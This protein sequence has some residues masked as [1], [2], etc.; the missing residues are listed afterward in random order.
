M[1]SALPVKKYGGMQEF[2]DSDDE[3]EEDPNQAVAACRALAAEPPQPQQQGLAR[4]RNRYP[5]Q[6][7][8]HCIMTRI[9]A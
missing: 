8:A 4:R 7:V 1:V 3:A 5:H 9:S 2:V 6:Q